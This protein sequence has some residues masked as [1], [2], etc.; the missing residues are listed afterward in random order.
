MKIVFFLISILTFCANITFAQK[1][2]QELERERLQLQREIAENQ[3]IR[4]K[5]K[6][7]EN[8]S[9]SSLII[10]GRKAELQDKVVDNISK[11]INILDNSIYGL[12]RDLNKYDRLL[13]T[14]RQEYAKS[15]VYAYKNRGNYEFL[16]FIFS[17]DNF[18]DAVKRI[19]YL[20]S[21]RTFRQMQGQNILRT[22]ELRRN[23][24]E[25]LGV[26]KQS[27]SQTLTVQEQELKKVAEQKAEQNRIVENLRKQ[28]KN[29]DALIA[30]KQ[31]MQLKTE[32]LIKKAIAKAMKEA[33]DKRIAAEKAE[34]IK[35]EAESRE[36]LRLENIRKAN[37]AK[38]IAAAKAKA[39]A[40]ARAAAAATA[41]DALKGKPSPVTT[42]TTPGI[43]NPT[44]VKIPTSIKAPTANTPV[45][46]P[47]PTPATTSVPKPTAPKV[48][49]TPIYTSPASILN[50]NFERNRG[51]LPWPVDSRDIFIHYGPYTLPSGAKDVSKSV[52]IAASVGSSVKT[53]FDGN[54]IMAEE[55]EYGKYIIC[56]QHGKYYTSYINVS[57]VSVKVGQEVKTGQQIG[58]V[59][60]NIDGIG[61]IEFSLSREFN[62]IN[63]E[64]WLRR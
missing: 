2:R 18:N 34:R 52:S 61:A 5:I 13:D 28:G 19:S 14:L 30:D 32:S 37:E 40:D 16:N 42:T 20:K 31:R 60:T 22:Q 27:K 7:K 24:L 1:T 43:K 46:A 26:T 41:K 50:A 17:A 49:E 51:S 58:K 38:V 8:E 57:G 55:L 29:V 56:I 63:P 47:A 12:Q 23:K 10:V 62:E 33:N 39:D 35:R 11:D 6:T 54:V 53:V 15:M 4:E 48:A 3:R 9:L 44:S 64:M 59:A 36:A 45:P 21:Y 25:S